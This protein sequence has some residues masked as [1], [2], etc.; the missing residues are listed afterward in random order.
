MCAIV[1]QKINAIKTLDAE[2]KNNLHSPIQGSMNV[3]VFYKYTNRIFPL[4]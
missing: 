3:D 4:S 1:T 2:C